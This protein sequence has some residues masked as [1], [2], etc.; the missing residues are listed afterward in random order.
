[1][2]GARAALSDSDKRAYLQA[3]AAA[4]R[5]DFAAAS[6]LAG[7][8]KDRSL[9]KVILW[10]KLQAPAGRA[11]FE[12]IAGFVEANPHW[13]NR[14]ILRRRAEETIGS[15]IPAQ[16]VIGWFEERPPL[17]GL[18]R[19]RF[20][21]AL[22]SVGRREEAEAWLKSAWVEGNFSLNDERVVYDR[23]R[24]TL[25]SG[26][27]SAR[28]DRLLWD[29]QRG[30]AR[31]G[32]RRVDADL[33]ALGEARLS[34][35]EQSGG[36]DAAI[37][38][39]P[40]DLL[41]NS[42]LSYERTR[43]RRRKGL[44]ER[45]LD[46]LVKAP[47]DPIALVRP[48]KW[49][50]E[51]NIQS[52]RLL[53]EGDIAGAYD[54]ARR[55]GLARDAELSAPASA[56][57]PVETSYR[58]SFAEAEW[59]AGWIALEFIGDA[60]LA[61][62]HFLRLFATVEYPISIARASY[63]AGRAAM[64]RQDPESARKWFANAAR[65]TS[66]FY[67]QLAIRQRETTDAFRLQSPPQPS[68]A[69]VAAFQENELVKVIR[70]LAELS[71][72]QRLRPFFYALLESVKSPSEKALVAALANEVGRI[73][74]GVRMAKL[75]SQ[76]DLV[77]VDSAYPTTMFPISAGVEQALLHAISRQESEFN[78]QAVSPVGA[79]GL[80]QLMP[81]TARAVAKSLQ[82][83][84]EPQRLTTD[85][86]YNML[87]GSAHLRD[88]LDEF[89]GSYVL[90]I[91]AYNAGSGNVRRWIRL[92]GDPRLDDI[93]PIT[94]IEMIPFSETR[95]YVQRVLENVQIYRY[96]LDPDGGSTLALERD[97]NRTGAPAAH[98]PLPR[99]KPLP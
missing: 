95:N 61:Y 77:L 59:L 4:D 73:D 9:A 45:A 67:G 16:R 6:S 31:R 15:S 37:A 86:S 26:D 56:D 89:D 74:L 12:E 47:N 63:W 97:L 27:H 30:A 51:R 42:G 19:V 14:D 93:D 32:L 10:L 78:L 48:D 57:R 75:A 90:A 21:D 1:M 71:E 18:G 35:M 52:R 70:V 62:N 84:Y 69:E 80:M 53:R 43:W 85:S 23:H 65:Y 3:L 8:A 79:R 20:A 50:V 82:I 81:Y 72:G 38:R 41:E 28:L 66:T 44:D 88:L 33:R 17:S 64:V 54:L 99:A 98:V 34:L 58:E 5:N 94:W 25:D 2:G 49:W 83:A 96:R 11:T 40:D 39:V 22:S 36:V 13:P 46:L 68:E 29:G 7:S 87:L 24:K 76:S 91:A 55:H 92:F 60:N